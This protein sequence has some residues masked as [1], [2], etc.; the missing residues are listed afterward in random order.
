MQE[1]DSSNEGNGAKNEDCS[2]G[3]GSRSK[4]HIGKE[5]EK[6]VCISVIKI[7]NRK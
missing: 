6:G 7:G 3:G 1:S 4:I 5:F 2:A